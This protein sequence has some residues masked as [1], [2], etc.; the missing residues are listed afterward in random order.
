MVL[1]LHRH[2]GHAHRDGPARLALHHRH[3]FVAAVRVGDAVAGHLVLH[4]V[5]R[6]AALHL[7]RHLLVLRLVAAA[8]HVVAHHGAGDRTGG[9]RGFLAVAGAHLV[10]QQAAHD[11]ADRDTAVV[12][13]AAAHRALFR[14]GFGAAFLAR[15]LHLLVLRFDAAHARLVGE[16]EVALRLGVGGDAGGGEQGEDEGSFHCRTPCLSD[17]SLANG[18]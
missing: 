12:G 18:P 2:H 10:A 3:V 11:G 14:H 7:A 15:H 13:A 4:L 6:A 16:G 1:R 9:R 5:D 17:S 8:G